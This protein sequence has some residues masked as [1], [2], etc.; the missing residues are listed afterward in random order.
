MDYIAA[1]ALKIAIYLNDR[2]GWM[3]GILTAIPVPGPLEG[4]TSCLK[5]RA[6]F[7]KVR[8]MNYNGAKESSI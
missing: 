4:C 7:G 5:E 6:I 3:E 2:Y 1:E 8:Y